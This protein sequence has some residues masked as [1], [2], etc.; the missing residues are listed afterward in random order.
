MVVQLLEPLVETIDREKEGL[1]IRDVYCDRHPQRP[2]RFPHRVEAA[3]VDRDE[4]PRGN[5]LAQ[6]QP[7][8]L[9]DLH[10]ARAELVRAPDVVRLVARVV[11]PVGLAPPRLGERDESVGVRRLIGLDALLQSFPDA[12]RQVDHRL[13]IHAIH[14]RQQLG[15]WRRE[16]HLFTLFGRHPRRAESEV[17]VEIDDGISRARHA[18][19]RNLEHAARLEVLQIEDRRGGLGSLPAPLGHPCGGQRRKR[20]GERREPLTAVHAI[21][22]P[23]CPKGCTL[24]LRRPGPPVNYAGSIGTASAPPGAPPRCYTPA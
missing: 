5:L 2:A 16:P 21:H 11:R 14:H 8:R 13:E 6:V 3:V 4:R 15:G 1:G 20:G 23:V 24:F 10:A 19:G 12:A 18:R 22:S 17:R 9:E 7:Q